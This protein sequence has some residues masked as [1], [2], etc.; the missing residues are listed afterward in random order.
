[1]PLGVIARFLITP[2]NCSGSATFI[3][4]GRI[5]SN[6]LGGTIDSCCFLSEPTLETAFEEG[7]MPDLIWLIV[8]FCWLGGLISLSY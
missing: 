5:D 3:S 4:N 7:L 6:S 8:N 1:V 2:P